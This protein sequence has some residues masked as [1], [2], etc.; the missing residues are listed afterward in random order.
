[1]LQRHRCRENEAACLLAAVLIDGCAKCNYSQ[2]IGYRP[3]Q[4]IIAV[5]NDDRIIDVCLT[6][7]IVA[8]RLDGL[9]C[10]LSLR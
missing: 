2:Y 7:L 10:H 4:L 3:T 5:R 1:M 6:T 8:K 9:R